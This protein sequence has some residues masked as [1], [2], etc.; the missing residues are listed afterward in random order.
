MRCPT[1]DELPPPPAGKTGWPWTEESPQ[2]PDT[3]PGG[4]HWP[5]VSIVTP[6]YNQGQFI[7]ETIRS[8][9]LQGYPDL[10]YIIIDGGSTDGSVEIIRKYEH[11]LAYWVSEP[12]RGQSEAINKGWQRASG[13]IMAWLNSDDTYGPGAVARAVDFFLKRS[14]ADIIYGGVKFARGDGSPICSVAAREPFDP[15]ELLLRDFI[16]Q[17]ATF[18]RRTAVEALGWLD[19]NLHHAMDY[20]YWLR[21]VAQGCV[22]APVPGAP[23]ARFRIHETSKSI[24]RA[25][26]FYPE[27]LGILENFFTQ[28]GLPTDLAGMKYLALSQ[29]YLDWA[30]V[31]HANG[32]RKLARQTALRALR[33]APGQLF[34]RPA[35]VRLLL[36]SV[37]LP[38][39]WI[40][41]PL[42]WHSGWDRAVAS[43]DRNTHWKDDR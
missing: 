30:F 23:L 5:R 17:P 38:L 14:E 11:R 6:S 20:G 25:E 12:D 41:R 22:L 13:Q 16:S 21:A 35:V 24:S 7:E 8:V 26:R 19:T 9:L 15:R 39:G 28:P 18:L 2:L 42:A 36:E 32:Q 3:M 43:V 1:L 34:R 10:E 40:R 33:L 29:A 37:G 31:W 27:I 4:S